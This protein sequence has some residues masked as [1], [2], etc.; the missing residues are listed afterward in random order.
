MGALSGS[1]LAVKS[2]SFRAHHP[3][4]ICLASSGIAI[5]G[6]RAVSLGG[7]ADL[8]VASADGGRRTAV[9]WFQ[10]PS[11]V[12]A[13]LAARVWADVSGRERRWVQIS[14]VVDAP[15]DVASPEG[16]A[17][18]AAVRAAA[19]RALAEDARAEETP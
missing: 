6:L 4:E 3:P 13:D 16:L 18:V 14:I 11:R 8:R 7:G 1:L 9:Y 17:L 2:R 10:S 15:L 5:E 12:T 19:A